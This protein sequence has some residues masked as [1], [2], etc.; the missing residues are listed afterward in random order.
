MISPR[1]RTAARAI[2]ICTGTESDNLQVG[3]AW[4]DLKGLRDIAFFPEAIKTYFSDTTITVPS[5]Y[6]GDCN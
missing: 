2:A 5:T 6:L 4:L 3:V 1:P